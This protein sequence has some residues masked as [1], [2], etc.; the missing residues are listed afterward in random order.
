MIT[1]R[2]GSDRAPLFFVH[3]GIG[4]SW[5]YAEFVK[6]L[7]LDQPVYGLQLTSLSGGPSFDSLTELADDY[8]NRI[9]AVA[10]T[11]PIHLA[12]WSLGA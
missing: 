7:E 2:A 1:L 11:G 12:G 5:G 3:P 10:S 8:A 6:H 4:L 9:A